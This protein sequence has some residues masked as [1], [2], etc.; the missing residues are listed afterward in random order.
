M[1]IKTL[2]LALVSCL[3]AVAAPAVAQPDHKTPLL[4][5]ERHLSIGAAS[6]DVTPPGAVYVGGNG[7]G[8][9]SVI[10]G[11]LASPGG[12]RAAESE[13]L[14]ARAL[15]VDNGNAALGF[16]IVPNIGMF[17]RYDEEFGPYGLLD[18][19]ESIEQATS[20]ALPAGSIF[21]AG[22]HSHSG[23]DTL[24]AWGGV[25]ADYLKQVHDGA[26]AAVVAAFES[27]RPAE[28][29]AGSVG[30]RNRTFPGSGG[31]YDLLDNQV[32]LETADNSFEGPGNRCVPRQESV[33]DA[34]RVLQAREILSATTAAENSAKGCEGPGDHDG[35][36]CE[37]PGEVIATFLSF[38]AHP[39]L[40][41]AGGLHGDWP[42][43]AAQAI[44]ATYGGVGIAW[45]GAIG[46]IQPERGW[47]DRK[48]DYS[49]N[50]ITL[51]NEAL[52]NASPLSASNVAS[53][54]KL[55]RS[56][57]T[58]PVLA[59]LLL[60]GEVVGAR[61]MRSRQDPWMVG[62]TIATVVSAARIGDL[63]FLG[64]PGEAYPQIAL[65]AANAIEGE[66]TLITLGLADD[67][68]GYLISHIEDYP[69]LAAISAINDNALFNASPR[70]GDHVMCAGIR[71]AADIGFATTLTPQ[72]ARCA[73]FDAEDLVTGGDL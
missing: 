6:R 69:V 5:A 59:G 34:V 63:A 52:A 66:R 28:L 55:I 46:R 1:T 21:A 17:A 9:G 29:V 62:N 43:H 10:P 70:I 19:A 50:L 20:G 61:L 26:V 16:V 27:R 56:E 60:H 41:G 14:Y 45:P 30:S 47:S 32:C 72:T 31:T 25:S 42:E 54:K 35:R 48:R 53:S 18:I 51:M 23:P 73:A 4:S 49:N 39:T 64:V 67:M 24:G 68:L 71:A 33:D 8:D 7:L 15:V 58:N 36:Q 38:A 13:R 40:G 65:E 3:V 22:N 11:A 2:V 12:Q 57:V 44:E 37:R